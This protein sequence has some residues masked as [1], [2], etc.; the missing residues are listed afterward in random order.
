MPTIFDK[1]LHN[2]YTEKK[3]GALWQPQK[4]QLQ[5]KQHIKVLGA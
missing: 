1:Q 4:K 3:G 5:A 2:A